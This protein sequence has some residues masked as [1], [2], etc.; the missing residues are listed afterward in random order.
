MQFQDFQ[1]PDT[2]AITM[3]EM[4]SSWYENPPNKASDQ[5]LPSFSYI[6]AQRTSHK[7]CSFQI[8]PT[9]AFRKLSST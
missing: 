1:T 9:W 2:F 4:T 3:A 8:L 7:R 5:I 6:P